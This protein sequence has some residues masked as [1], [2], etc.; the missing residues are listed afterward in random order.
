[1]ELINTVAETV[2]Q[3]LPMFMGGGMGGPPFDDEESAP[4]DGEEGELN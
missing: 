2:R 3:V 4:L 1:M